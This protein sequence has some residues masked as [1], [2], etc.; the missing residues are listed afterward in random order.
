MN[1][2]IFWFFV[3]IFLYDILM[4]VLNCKKYLNICLISVKLFNNRIMLLGYIIVRLIVLIYLVDKVGVYYSYLCFLFI[5]LLN[6]FFVI[7]ILVIYGY[8]VYFCYGLIIMY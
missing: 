8:V 6:Y 2:K 7:V 1:F 5:Y 4:G 3:I